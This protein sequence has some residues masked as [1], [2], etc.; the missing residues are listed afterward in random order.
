MHF[1]AFC[2]AS[3]PTLL[4]MSYFIYAT[5]FLSVD[6]AEQKSGGVSAVKYSKLSF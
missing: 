4:L 1:A 5:T 2:K 3:T 6:L